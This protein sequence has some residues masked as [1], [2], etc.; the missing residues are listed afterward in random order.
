MSDINKRAVI[1]ADPSGWHSEQLRTSFQ[2]RGIEPVFCST[3]RLQ[4]RLGAENGIW[5]G[6]ERLHEVDLVLVRE[7]PSGSLEQII[8][9][10]DA[11]HQ[12]ED[13]GV[14]VINTPG[15][16]EKMVDKYY[17]SSLCAN[18]GL[19]VPETIVTE[20]SEEAMQ[21]FEALGCDVVVKPL[22]GSR[23]VGMV[24][25]TERDTARRVF[26]ALELGRYIYYLQKFIPH[27]DYDVRLFFVGEECAAAMTRH[28]SGWKTNL[29]QGAEPRF[30]NPPDDMLEL[31][32][33][34]LRAVRAD[35]CGVDILPGEDG[36]NYILEVNS[37]PSWIGL[38]TVTERNIADELVQY[39]LRIKEEL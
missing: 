28:G 11:L 10:M 9:R 32:K 36:T 8:Y 27:G 29:S 38:Q 4:A 13:S 16:I 21:A 31:G 19:H 5:N 30:F 34:A 37:M 24:R 39:C 14:R 6:M 26:A 18:T 3:N 35:Y 15:A 12:L 1:L 22:F 20:N 2:Q 23:G 33:R 17:T 7:V 25:L